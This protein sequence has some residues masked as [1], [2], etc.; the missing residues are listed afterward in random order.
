MTA[1]DIESVMKNAE[2]SINHRQSASGSLH[3]PNRLNRP[4]FIYDSAG[5]ISWWRFWEL[6]LRRK[7]TRNWIISSHRTG[8][9]SSGIQQHAPSVQR[10]YAINNDEP[11]RV[12]RDWIFKH[13][14]E[15]TEIFNT[16][17]WLF[18]NLEPIVK[19]LSS[20]FLCRN[21]FHL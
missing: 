21:K 18:D 2:T 3:V 13:A 6:V 10:F 1:K 11:V 17:I 19:K 20:S 8:K 9:K 14:K 12:W 4:G 7:L 16:S 5:T 15:N